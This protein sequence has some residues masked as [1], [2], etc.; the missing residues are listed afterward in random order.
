MNVMSQNLPPN[1]FY[2]L[3]N[4]AEKTLKLKSHL[5]RTGIV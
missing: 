4:D 1:D 3:R 2:I 5:V